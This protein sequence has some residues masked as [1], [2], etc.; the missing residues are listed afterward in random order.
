MARKSKAAVSEAEAD[1]RR[2]ERIIEKYLRD[3]YAAR[4]VARVSELARLLEKNRPTFS[5]TIPKIFGR[6]L[7]TL[8]RERQI[9]ESSATPARDGPW[10]RRDRIRQRIG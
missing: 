6:S 7:G 8:L 9:A 3:C 1:R 2:Y 4:T 5:R 10:D